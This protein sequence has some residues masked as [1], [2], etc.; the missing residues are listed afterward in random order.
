M[1]LRHLTFALLLLLLSS[2]GFQLRSYSFE[3]ALE[4]YALT[5]QTRASVVPVL[6]RTLSQVGLNEVSEAE[7]A[8][9]LEILDQRNERRSASTSGNV[10]AAEYEV[11]YALH[12]QILSADGTV[13]A[14]PTWIERQRIYRI[15]RGNIVG[16]SEEQALLQ[17]E[18]MQD[19]AGQLMRAMDLVSRQL[20]QNQ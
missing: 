2:C 4:N 15:D 6:R 12:Y 3:G 13:L 19:V 18:L 17:R 14:P 9:V 11:D 20:Q 16:S 5:G 8:L 7:A 10:R 1:L